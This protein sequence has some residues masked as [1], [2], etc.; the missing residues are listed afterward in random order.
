[1]NSGVPLPP[2]AQGVL[3]LT[4]ITLEYDEEDGEDGEL[5]PQELDI[6][7]DSVIQFMEHIVLPY[8]IVTE[9]IQNDKLLNYRHCE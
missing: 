1:M 3:G 8:L 9:Y 7:T 2:W 4:E 6:N 5:L